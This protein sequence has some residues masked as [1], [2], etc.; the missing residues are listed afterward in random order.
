MT[1]ASDRLPIGYRFVSPFLG[2]CE[3]TNYVAQTPEQFMRN[4]PPSFD[5][6]V[7]CG[8]ERAKK[9]MTAEFVADQEAWA[10]SPRPRPGLDVLLSDEQAA[11]VAVASGWIEDTPEARAAYLAGDE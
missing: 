9:Y 5:Y 2:D 10:R 11:D 1:V 7:R 4:E 8:S 3:I 6:V